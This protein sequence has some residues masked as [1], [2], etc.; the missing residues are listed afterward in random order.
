MVKPSYISARSIQ[1]LTMAVKL[2][3][4]T[5]EDIPGMVDVWSSSFSDS[6]E[7]NQKWRQWTADS[8]SMGILDP[9]LNVFHV[10]IMEE[11]VSSADEEQEDIEG[12]PGEVRKI[13]ALARWIY[14][15]GGG[16]GFPKWW[17]RW[18]REPPEGVSYETMGPEFYDVMARQHDAIMSDEPHYCT[19]TLDFRVLLASSLLAKLIV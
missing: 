17:T 12:A 9:N 1:D 6:A 2:S 15:P 3:L 18:R 13:I 8:F 19:Q 7:S 14:Y 5:M 11:P 16:G 4:A 10:V